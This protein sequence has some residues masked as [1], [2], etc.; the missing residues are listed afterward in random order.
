MTARFATATGLLVGAS[1][2]TAAAAAADPGDTVTYT[3][4]S[5]AP[6]VSVSYYDEMDNMRQV[7]DQ[8][9]S[10]STTFTSEATSGLFA[11]DA[12]T[13]GEEVH[14]Q[15]TING[16]VRDQKS[17]VGLNSSANCS[18]PIYPTSPTSAAPYASSLIH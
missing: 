16:E 8:P 5:D 1:L 12:Q 2:T 10:W 13:T 7:A 3:V 15:I 4:S 17:A 9:A 18:A 11:V 14:C 6:L